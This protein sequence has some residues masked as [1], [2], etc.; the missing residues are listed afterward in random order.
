MFAGAKPR[1]RLKRY[2]QDLEHPGSKV[3]QCAQS[4]SHLFFGIRFH[5][6]TG[7]RC[8]GAVPYLSNEILKIQRTSAFEFILGKRRKIS[9]GAILGYTPGYCQK[10]HFILWSRP[11]APPF[12]LPARRR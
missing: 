11:L 7:A 10:L 1:V 2:Y 5:Q 3:R 12:I 9:L 8:V 6:Q 4:R